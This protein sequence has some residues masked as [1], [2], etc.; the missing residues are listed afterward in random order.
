[1]P[2]ISFLVPETAAGVRLE[3]DGPSFEYK[4]AMQIDA[5]DSTLADSPLG[6]LGVGAEVVAM[7]GEPCD[8]LLQ[9]FDCKLPAW[10]DFAD[11]VEA[12]LV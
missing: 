11:F 7:D 3:V 12:I 1:M 9:S 5:A 4:P 2:R 6:I 8:E 10:V